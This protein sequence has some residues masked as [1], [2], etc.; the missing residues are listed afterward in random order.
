MKIIYAQQPIPKKLSSLEKEIFL[1]G[2]TPR[3]PDVPSWRPDALKIIEELEYDGIVF[4]PEPEDG[5]WLGNYNAQIDWEWEALERSRVIAAWVPRD[6]ETMPAFTTNIEFGYYAAKYD[7]YNKALLYGRPD[8]APKTRY[9][10]RLYHKVTRGTQEPCN[11]LEDLMK[12][13]V[14]WIQ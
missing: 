4:V 10:D 11:T 1:V 13:A 14:R 8:D 5:K 9:L 3:H 12:L 7:P 2:P 6:L